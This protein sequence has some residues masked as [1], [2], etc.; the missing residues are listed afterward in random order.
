MVRNKRQ[1]KPTF[2]SNRSF[3]FK[4]LPDP[5][6]IRIKTSKACQASGVKANI[7]FNK[8]WGGKSNPNSLVSIDYCKILLQ[9]T[10]SLCPSGTGVDSV[11]F[12]ETCFFSRIPVIIS[13]SYTMGHEF[14]KE[15][16]FYFQIDPNISIEKMAIKIR[17]IE[18]TPVNNLKDMC[19]NSKRFYETVVCGYLEDPTL[20][21]MEWIR[22]NE[23]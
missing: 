10:F 13:D 5:R 20:T 8:S 1:I 14:N 9:N 11:R 7:I 6:G 15:Y 22:N 3:G 4:G 21:F 16:P 17:E 18:S 23:K 2:E 12:F 19:Y